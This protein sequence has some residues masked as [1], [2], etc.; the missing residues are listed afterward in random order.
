M[1]HYVFGLFTIISV[2]STFNIQAKDVRP[3]ILICSSRT[4]F[5]PTDGA[6]PNIYERVCWSITKDDN[7]FPFP[8]AYIKH[9]QVCLKK[10]SCTS[11]S[12]QV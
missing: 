4:L 7:S 3:A 11:I 12:N 9:G 5:S 6:N 8:H 2:T 10:S 1:P